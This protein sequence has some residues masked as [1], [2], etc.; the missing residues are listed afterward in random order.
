MNQPVSHAC[1]IPSRAL[2]GFRCLTIDGTFLDA[3]PTISKAQITEYRVFSSLRKSSKSIP[4]IN[5]SAF[6]RL[7][8][9][10]CKNRCTFCR[11]SH[12]DLLLQDTLSYPAFQRS[13]G[14]KIH[15]DSGYFPKSALQGDKPG[16]SGRLFEFHQHVKIAA[17]VLLSSHKRTKE[18]DIA[19][20]VLLTEIGQIFTKGLDDLIESWIGYWYFIL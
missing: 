8:S 15:F 17:R 11:F 3:S 16:K 12:C 20:A 10:S 19:H 2:L 7:S 14:H 6:S 5:P 18:P 9:M 4:A 1:H 13:N